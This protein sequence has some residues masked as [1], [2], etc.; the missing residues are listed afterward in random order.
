MS[1][2]SRS[3]F[4]DLLTLAGEKSTGQS[5]ALY[6]KHGAC[7][8]NNNTRPADLDWIFANHGCFWHRF[9]SSQSKTISGVYHGKEGCVFVNQNRRWHEQW[10]TNLGHLCCSPEPARLTQTHTRGR[11]T[12]QCEVGVRQHNQCHL[13]SFVTLF[14]FFH[15]YYTVT[16]LYTFTFSHVVASCLKHGSAAICTVPMSRTRCCH[17][18]IKTNVIV[19]HCISLNISCCSFIK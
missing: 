11:H 15:V 6:L 19:Y 8:H 3:T 12:S 16:Y 9:A 1:S 17:G 7:D 13:F 18:K 14:T 4:T 10:P 2:Q 5:P